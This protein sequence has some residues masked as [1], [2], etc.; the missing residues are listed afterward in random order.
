[1]RAA[2]W[3]ETIKD[4]GG[5][6]FQVSVITTSGPGDTRYVEHAGQDWIYHTATC[7]KFGGEYW[8]I[9]P[10]WFPSGPVP[11]V[12]WARSLGGSPFVHHVGPNGV[13]LHWILAGAWNQQIRHVSDG[14][15][16]CPCPECSSR[17]G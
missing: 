2:A 6:A 16:T 5:Q 4:R 13:P 7:V 15:F 11:I 12:D 10:E 9:D 1:M 3:A 14:Y 17:M 8:A